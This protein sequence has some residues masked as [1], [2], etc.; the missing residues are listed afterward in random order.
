MNESAA[1][2]RKA[3]M[4]DIQFSLLFSRFFIQYRQVIAF[5]DK[6]GGLEASAARPSEGV[7]GQPRMAC[8]FRI[9]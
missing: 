8:R 2:E 4:Y 1:H 5:S 6:A 3:R 9:L 7:T